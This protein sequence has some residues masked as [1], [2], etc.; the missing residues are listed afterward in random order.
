MRKVIRLIVI[1]FMIGLNFFLLSCGGKVDGNQGRIIKK[2][3]TLLDNYV[4]GKNR[5][6]IYIKQKGWEVALTNKYILTEDFYYQLDENNSF[7]KNFKNTK[8]HI[9][10]SDIEHP[11]KPEFVVDLKNRI[12][13]YQEG[14]IPIQFWADYIYQGK[15]YLLVNIQ[16]IK[17]REY[18]DVVLDI[19]SWTVQDKPL[20][21]PKEPIQESYDV[22]SFSGTNLGD[23]L[24]RD[25]LAILH[26][27]ISYLYSSSKSPVLKKYRFSEEYSMVSDAFETGKNSAIYVRPNRVSQE[28]YYQDLR[29][30]FTPLGQDSIIEIYQTDPK[31][32][33]NSKR[34][35]FED[36]RRRW[37]E[38]SN[39]TQSNQSSSN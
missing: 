5:Q 4:F 12:D 14:Y 30:W 7:D 11:N 17:S 15:E 26:G 32:D 8:F 6:Y 9:I 18:K 13:K 21:F 29:R 34:N 20:D 31:V 25:N 10:V 19:D 38:D 33:K 23:S 39:G 27:R 22:S 1:C 36:F 3:V 24:S 35:T 2:Q 16:N 28:E 37:K